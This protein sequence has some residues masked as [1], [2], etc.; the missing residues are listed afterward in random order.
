MDCHSNKSF[1][2]VD[3]NYWTYDFKRKIEIIIYFVKV[4][5][6]NIIAISNKKLVVINRYN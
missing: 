5:F 4:I 3:V 1:A 6:I 2:I